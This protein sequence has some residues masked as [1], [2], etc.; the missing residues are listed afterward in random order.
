VDKRWSLKPGAAWDKGQPI[1]RL[2]M[3]GFPGSLDAA[4][5]EQMIAWVQSDK[6]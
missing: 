2:V 3:I 6:Y 5:M 4:V 1:S